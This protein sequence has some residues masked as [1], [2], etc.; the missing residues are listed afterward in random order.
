[1][2]SST[3]RRV[4]QPVL[5]GTDY[6]QSRRASVRCEPVYGHAPA[7]RR[8]VVRK[9][10]RPSERLHWLS[11]TAIKSIWNTVLQLHPFMSRQT[12]SYLQ[13]SGL[14]RISCCTSLRVRASPI[15]SSDMMAPNG[16]SSSSS[17]D[18]TE[19]SSSNTTDMTFEKVNSPPGT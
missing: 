8:D 17:V 12:L 3:V 9:R 5:A 13:H 14:R 2:E 4:K 11:K 15:P 10:R 18:R 16:V 6:V 7:E 1:M 19:E